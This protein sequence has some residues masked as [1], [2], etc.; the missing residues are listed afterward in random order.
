MRKMLQVRVSR[1]SHCR[2][3]R[4]LPETNEEV[5]KRLSK[6]RMGCRVEPVRYKQRSTITWQSQGRCDQCP[7]KG[8]PNIERC[9]DDDTHRERMTEQGL[10]EDDIRERYDE[11]KNDRVHCTN[12][13]DKQRCETLHSQSDVFEEPQHAHASPRQWWKSCSW[14]DQ[15]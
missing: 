7:K 10:N 14:D 12:A 13:A 15:S 11:A 3:G 9:K 6:S 4:I 1:T 2:Y 5:Q 8:S